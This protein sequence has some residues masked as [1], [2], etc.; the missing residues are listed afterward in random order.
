MSTF[1]F[2]TAGRIVFG[3]GKVQELPSWVGAYGSR[4]FVITGSTPARY[5]QVIDLLPAAGVFGVGNEPKIENIR[6]GVA[7][8][9]EYGADV[10]VG[11]GGG[12][13]MD[14]AKMIAAL[15]TNGGDP[16]DYAE[17]IGAGKVLSVD[18][19]PVIAVPTTSGT[20][21]E[22]TANGV[23]TSGEHGLKVSLRSPTML[24]KVALV[25]PE[26]TLSVPPQVSAFSGLDALVQCIEPYVS[27]KANPITDGLAQIAIQRAALG[28]RAAFFDGADLQARTHMSMVSLLSGMCLANAG[29]GGAHG[30]AGV[31]G[32][33]TGAPH[34]AITASVMV[35]VCE[36]NVAAAK[37]GRGAADVV[38]RYAQVGQWLCGEQSAQAGI[39][40]FG[41]TASLL[42]VPGLAALGVSEDQIPALALGA[43]KASS[44][45]GNPVQFSA[46]EFEAII[47][48]S[49]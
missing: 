27:V 26:L 29:L 13:A 4:P 39:A 6:D 46:A 33:A 35:A 28:L 49:L 22:V 41:E 45:K 1:S 25:D 3:T 5:Q 15:L 20:G 2:V 36:A 18:A 19:L 12:A 21:S 43:T 38:E 10:V 17:V 23:L 7:A 47:A 42:G 24:P 32:G 37:A 8:A 34:G 9:G 14:S 48:A 44:S 11:L 16:L 40:W 30:L 31:I